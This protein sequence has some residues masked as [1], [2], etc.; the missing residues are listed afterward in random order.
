MIDGHDYITQKKVF[1][2]QSYP[3]H[4]KNNKKNKDET[5]GKASGGSL[6]LEEKEKKGK[7][8]PLD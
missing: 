5:K 4:F 2:E 1:H 7:R 6:S 8:K 3:N